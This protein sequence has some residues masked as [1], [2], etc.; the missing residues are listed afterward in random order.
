MAAPFTNSFSKVILW[1]GWGGFTFC[2]FFLVHAQQ[3]KNKEKNKRAAWPKV[4]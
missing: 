3:A 2:N 1:G 4:T